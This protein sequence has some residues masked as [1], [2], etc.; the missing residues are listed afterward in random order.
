MG[1]NARTLNAELV[2]LESGPAPTIPD[3]DLDRAR[4]MSLRQA[5]LAAVDAIERRW[6]VSPTTS[7]LRKDMQRA[8][9]LVAQPS[10]N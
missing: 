3:E 7:E 4:D 2:L 5:Y 6:A 8:K 9:K 1:I 10:G